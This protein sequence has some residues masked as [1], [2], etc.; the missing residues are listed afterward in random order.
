[1]LHQP[2]TTRRQ[3]PNG[4]EITPSSSRNH[5]RPN[6]P[7]V[8][9]TQ[10]LW[11][12]FETQTAKALEGLSDK[13]R[14]ASTGIFSTRMCSEQCAVHRRV[15]GDDSTH[16]QGQ[17]DVWVGPDGALELPGVDLDYEGEGGKEGYGGCCVWVEWKLST[18]VQV[19]GTFY[20][21]LLWTL[22]SGFCASEHE[23]R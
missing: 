15:Q 19:R 2:R 11:C 23:N 4:T 22:S 16:V 7:L 17:H 10:R 9:P 14:T 18:Y 13:S 12:W 5:F 1:M 3:H 6:L 21:V 20:T 8:A